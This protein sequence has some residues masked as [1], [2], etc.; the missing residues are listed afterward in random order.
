M[1]LP[2]EVYILNSR[3]IF[4]LIKKESVDIITKDKRHIQILFSDKED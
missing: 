2:K 1:T 4:K 3:D